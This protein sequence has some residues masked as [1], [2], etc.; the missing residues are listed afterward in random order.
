MNSLL[1]ESRV[2]DCG[3]N[4]MTDNIKFNIAGLEEVLGK[5]AELKADIRL[6]GGRAAL[7]KA[8][9]VAMEAAKAN[10]ERIDDPQTAQNIKANIALR[11][12]NRRFKR[13][14]DLMFRVGVLGG[15]R[16]TGKSAL[17]SAARRRRQGVASLA[18]LGEIEGAGAGNPGGDTFHWRFIELGTS[19]AAAQPFL[20]P[21]LKQNITPVID[22]FASEYDKALGRAIKRAKKAAKKA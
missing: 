10:A 6:K 4:L 7:R 13:N 20:R 8:T 1:A 17:K 5:M 11:F 21:A 19:R 2:L 12:S 18:D 3:L 22:T 15:A 14:G 16:S 9:T